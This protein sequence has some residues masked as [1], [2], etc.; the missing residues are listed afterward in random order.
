MIVVE[1]KLSNPSHP[2]CTLRIPGLV[3][4]TLIPQIREF[5]QDEVNAS[6]VLMT[7]IQPSFLDLKHINPRLPKSLDCMFAQNI[8]LGRIVVVA[9][10]DASGGGKGFVPYTVVFVVVAQQQKVF[11]EDEGVVLYE[12]QGQQFGGVESG[13]GELEQVG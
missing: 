8:F 9:A 5:L 7:P 10:G 13:A 1:R 12:G 3:S 6:E 11:E 2:H 4:A